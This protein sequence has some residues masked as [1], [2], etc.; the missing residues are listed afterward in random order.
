MYLM[1]CEREK[2]QIRL[3]ITFILEAYPRYLF[4]DIFWLLTYTFKLGCQ[5]TRCLVGLTWSTC[6]KLILTQPSCRQPLS[7]RI[8]NGSSL[9][10][11]ATT[12]ISSDSFRFYTTPHIVT[13][14]YVFT[15]AVR[16]SVRACVCPSVRL[17][18]RSTYLRPH[19]VSVR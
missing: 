11:H 10:F 4:R 8:A 3:V 14:Y 6:K 1:I 7:S 17:S 16:V 15:L 13:G 2:T 9:I 19:L 18:V 12:A 5:W